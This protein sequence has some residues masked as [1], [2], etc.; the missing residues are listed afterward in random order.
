MLDALVAAAEAA[1]ATL[2]LPEVDARWDEPSALAGMTV[3]ALAG[4]F[5]AGLARLDAFL[6]GPEPDPSAARHVGVGEFFGT[7]RITTPAEHEDGMHAFIRLDAAERGAVGPDAVRASFATTWASLQTALVGVAPDR[8][9]PTKLPGTWTTLEVYLP[10]RVL[11]LAVH[12]DDLRCSVGAPDLVPAPEVADAVLGVGLAL[13][14]AASGDV[15]VLRA[16]FRGERAT[17]VLPVL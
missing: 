4:H 9:L 1:A 3:G 17:S 2:A 16:F 10:T 7:N 11:E 5:E 15:L 6:Q 12:T 8:R 14:R 13:A